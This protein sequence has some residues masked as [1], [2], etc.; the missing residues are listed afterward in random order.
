MA[1]TIVGDNRIGILALALVPGLDQALGV[2]KH[3]SMCSAAGDS[4]TLRL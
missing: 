3:L 4:L 2:L 1:V